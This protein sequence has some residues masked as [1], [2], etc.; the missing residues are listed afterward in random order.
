M[1]SKLITQ[2]VSNNPGYLVRYISYSMS[3]S[4]TSIIDSSNPILIFSG[5]VYIINGFF[6]EAE[7]RPVNPASRLNLAG[8]ENIKGTTELRLH[9]IF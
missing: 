7:S 1:H 5:N 3:V 6:L 8:E 4:L 9:I 2:G